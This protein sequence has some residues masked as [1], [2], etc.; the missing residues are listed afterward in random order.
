MSEVPTTTKKEEKGKAVAI[1]RAGEHEVRIT[2]DDVQKYPIT[3]PQVGETRLAQELGRKDKHRCIWHACLGCGKKRW[4]TLLGGKPRSLRCISCSH[5]G[6]KPIAPGKGRTQ[7][8]GYIYIKIRTSDF[9]YPMADDQGYVA[10]HRLVMAK[11]L[12][13]C[14]QSWEFVHHKNGLKD[15]NHL[16]NLKLTT[17][18]SHAIEHNKGY[19]D[20]YRQ[21]YMDGQDAQVQELRKEIRLLHWGLKQRQEVSNE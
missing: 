2:F 3:A 8:G 13:R 20:G 9:F 18:G 19:R 15:D 11:H 14:L 12:G 5:K 10:E 7:K 16:S 17:S 21:G 1:F 4:V 6:E